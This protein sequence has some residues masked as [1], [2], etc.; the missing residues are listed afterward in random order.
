MLLFVVLPH[1]W[2]IHLSFL[3]P[4]VLYNK[5]QLS[6][7]TWFKIPPTSALKFNV[8]ID[9]SSLF[10]ILSSKWCFFSEISNHI[11]HKNTHQSNCITYRIKLTQKNAY[12][13]VLCSKAAT[14][15]DNSR[16]SSSLLLPSGGVCRNVT[17][18]GSCCPCCSSDIHFS[19][20]LGSNFLSSEGMDRC[21]RDLQ[22]IMFRQII[23]ML[24]YKTKPVTSSSSSFETK[25]SCRFRATTGSVNAK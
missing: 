21:S 2:Y 17:I 3:I 16:R 11:W 23:L 20:N 10:Q 14:R 8:L 18:S 22:I 25:L 15:S 1:W 9:F 12:L 5:Q 19:K 4:Q 24:E 7:G 13:A 6:F